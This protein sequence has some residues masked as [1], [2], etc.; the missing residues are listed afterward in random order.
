MKTNLKK[1]EQE[2][3]VQTLNL[4]KKL[5]ITGGAPIGS[6]SIDHFEQDGSQDEANNGTIGSVSIEH[7]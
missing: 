5:K 6:V 4:K 2:N 7:L 3:V 1:F